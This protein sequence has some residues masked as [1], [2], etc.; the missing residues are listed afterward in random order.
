MIRTLNPFLTTAA[1]VC[2]LATIAYPQ[3]GAPQNVTPRNGSAPRLRAGSHKVDFT[4]KESELQFATDSIRD[5]LYARAIVVDEGGSCAVLVG[6]DLGAA[7]NQIIDDAIARASKSTGC[8]PQNFVISATHTHSSNTHGLGQG[9][10]AAKTVADAIVEAATV[11]KSRLAPARVGYGTTTI[12]LNVNRDLFNRKLEWR[13]DPNPDGPSDKTLAVVEILGDDNVP[14]GV[15]MNYAMHPVNFYL[16]GVISADFPGEASRY[17]E[18]LF[19]NRTV[20]IFSQGA[21]G[22]QNPRDFRSPATFFNA[23]RPRPS[24]PRQAIPDE[25]LEAHKKVLARTGDYVHMLGAF[26]GSSAVRVMRESIQPADT[27]RI[28]AA[29]ETFACPGRVR[30]DAD[31]PARENVFP[32]YKDGPDVNLKVGLLRIGD[33][34]LASVNGEVYSE[35]ATRL[36]NEAP[37]SK[38]MMV[39]LANGF[40]NSGYIYSDAAY[41]HL[42]FQVIGSRLKPGCAEDRIVSTVLDLMRRSGQ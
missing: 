24:G 42:T 2:L 3:N 19:D 30:L 38:T 39:T 32:G 34:H 9:A 4:P 16:S 26:I 7:P 27:A 29:Q 8:P 12:D 20:A 15:Y 31:N 1:V 25:N 10:P 5:H 14:I 6:M 18:E 17:V 13:Q 22:D 23:P 35:I 40:A 33:I 37:A 21:S 28:W 41:S 36:K 11:A